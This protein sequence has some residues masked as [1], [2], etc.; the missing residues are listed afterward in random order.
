MTIAEK[1]IE[2]VQNILLLQDQKVLFEI[3][4]L[5]KQAIEIQN[6][7]LTAFPPPTDYAK[8]RFFKSLEEISAEATANGLTPEI[9]EEIL[10][11]K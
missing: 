7:R 6:S 9:L 3:D 4:K 11:E 1:K 10:N 5:I 8:S 2:L